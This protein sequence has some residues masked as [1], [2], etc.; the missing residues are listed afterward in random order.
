MAL[1]KLFIGGVLTYHA[2]SVIVAR[3]IDFIVDKYIDHTVCDW[4]G[5]PEH[6]SSRREKTLRVA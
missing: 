6:A 1:L 5:R 3:V 2:S 4:M